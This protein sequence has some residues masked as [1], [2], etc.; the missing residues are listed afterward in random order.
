V[1]GLAFYFKTFTTEDTESYRG[2]PQG[3]AQMLNATVLGQ[4]K[5]GEDA[6]RSTYNYFPDLNASY[7]LFTSSQLMMFHHAARYSGRRLLYFR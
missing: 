1:V 2:T 4:E 5:G 3:R 7:R 6:R